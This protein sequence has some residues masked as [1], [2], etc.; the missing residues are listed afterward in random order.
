MSDDTFL[1]ALNLRFDAHEERLRGVALRMMGSPAEAEEMLAAARA[2]LDRDGGAAV[3]AWLTA[4]VGRTCVRGLQDRAASGPWLGGRGTADGSGATAGTTDGAST[5]GATVGT[6]DTTDPDAAA[7]VT[8][9]TTAPG[10]APGAGPGRRP[11]TGDPASVHVADVDSVWLALLVVLESLGAEERIAYV[12]HDLFG[13][14]PAEAA[15]ITGDSPVEV[16]RLARRARERVRGVGT[17]RGADDPGRQRVLVDR[18]LAAARAR[19]AR[20]LAAVLDPDVVAYSDRG[21]VH[22]APAVAEGAAAFARFADVSRPALVDGAV[23]AVAFVGGRPV[24]A[25][26]FTFRRE[27]IATLSVT[28]GEDRVKAL[29][30]AFPDW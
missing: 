16:A 12:L 30:L 27:R 7:G 18:F 1:A 4:L 2:G 14:P 20:A 5:A 21:P 25:L 23:G 3:R 29:D 9:D 17:V 10:P 6:T 26:M 8:A 24:A 22:G 13:L 19:D 11:P 15:R 28:A